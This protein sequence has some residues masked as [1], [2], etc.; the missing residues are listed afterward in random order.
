MDVIPKAFQDMCLNVLRSKFGLYGFD[1]LF[2]KRAEISK[3]VTTELED[4]VKSWGIELKG[5]KLEG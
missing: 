2:S 1:E 3:I 5:L 4:K